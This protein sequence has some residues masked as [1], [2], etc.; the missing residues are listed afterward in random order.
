MAASVTV[1]AIAVVVVAGML[2]RPW[3][4]REWQWALGGAAAVIALRC[5]P[6]TAAWA[7]IAGG[8]NVYAFLAGIAIVAEIARFGGVFDAL[9]VRARAA[10][11]RSR[12]R[13]FLLVFVAGAAVTA[14][15][16]NDTTALV[17]TPAVFAAL[18]GSGVDPLPY[19]YACAFVANA[20][21][22]VLPFSN[23]ANLVTYAGRLPRLSEWF[24]SFGLAAAVAVLGTY[25]LLWLIF[26]ARLHKP[27]TPCEAAPVLLPRARFTSLVVAACAAGMLL[28]AALSWNV[29]VVTLGL[30][31]A[32][33][34]A[35][36]LADRA[37]IAASVKRLP[38]QIL[39]LVAGLF[40]VVDALDRAGILTPARDLLGRAALLPPWIGNVAAAFGAG[41]ASGALNNLPVAMAVARSPV[42]P[43]VFHAAILGVDLGPNLCATGSLSTLLWLIAVRREGLDIS[44]AGFFRIGLGAGLPVL[45]LTALLIR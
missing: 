21:S 37:V 24:W 35:M 7:T 9:A 20:A 13:L 26:R 14:L 43:H 34:I 22:F 8:A 33:A 45:V 31:L 3:G 30:A 6:L 17:L 28:A 36:A 11:G 10:G 41:A 19:L 27:M 1:L 16:S 42:A 25:L 15:L 4:S 2:L 12:S 40:V 18:D 39:P 32:A 5:E 29:G 38:W 44:A 23:P